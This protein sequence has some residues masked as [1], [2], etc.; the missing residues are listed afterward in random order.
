MRVIRISLDYMKNTSLLKENTLLLDF[1]TETI[2]QD[3]TKNIQFL[4]P[5]SPRQIT[6][7]ETVEF[8][9]EYNANIPD[10]GKKL[11]EQLKRDLKLRRDGIFG[12]YPNTPVR[13]FL[14]KTEI[15]IKSIV[16]PP[17]PLGKTGF[18]S[19]VFG[20]KNSVGTPQPR[21]SKAK[22]SDSVLAAELTKYGSCTRS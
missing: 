14:M 4:K 5:G 12:C 7:G 9:C 15:A 21:E 11:H 8:Y 17:S 18:L 2:K 6:T 19:S 22:K 13:V 16:S 1:T 20:E 10:F 3:D